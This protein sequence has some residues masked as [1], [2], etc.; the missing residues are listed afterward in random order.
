M[1]TEIRCDG[2][3]QI[4]VSEAYSNYWHCE[5][6]GDTRRLVNGEIPD[7]TGLTAPGNRHYV[8]RLLQADLCIPCM[9]KTQG[10]TT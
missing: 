2:C 5:L 9:S 3:R 10:E 8:V 4:I 1:S 6:Q 7:D